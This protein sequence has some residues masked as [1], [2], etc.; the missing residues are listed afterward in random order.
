M[1]LHTERKIYGIPAHRPLQN[2]TARDDKN[3]EK[4]HLPSSDAKNDEKVTGRGVLFIAPKAT[5][6]DFQNG[7]LG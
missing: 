2:R 4:V 5:E 6:P 3:G 1:I 7:W